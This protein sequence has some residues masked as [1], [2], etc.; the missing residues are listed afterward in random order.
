MVA[1]RLVMPTPRAM[2]PPIAT[3]AGTMI[4]LPEV[5]GVEEDKY[6]QFTTP[7]SHVLLRQH[8][9]SGAC[10]QVLAAQSPQRQSQTPSVGA[11]PASCDREGAGPRSAVR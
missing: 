5:R 6:P 11:A 1:H 9:R 3:A 10:W 8:R 7:T 4:E 2:M